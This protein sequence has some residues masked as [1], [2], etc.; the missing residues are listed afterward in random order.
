MCAKRIHLPDPRTTVANDL[1]LQQIEWGSR[2]VDLG[3]GDAQLLDELRDRKN[4]DVLGVELDDE[5]F[6][7]GIARGVPILKADLN[8]GLEDLPSNGFD[9]AVLS[10]T[11][12]QINR[13]LEL[14]QE[15]FRVAHR[16]LVVVPNFAHWRVRIQVAMR[17]R[18]PVTDFLPYEWYESPNVHFLSMLDFRELAA[19]GNF[20][21]AREI[22]IVGNRAVQDAWMPNLRAHSA[23]YLLERAGEMKA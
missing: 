5:A 22:P 8:K 11:L 15:I 20:R 14:L 3:C 1:I 21:I 13:P 19:R 16:A 12:Q 10:Q 4:C 2:V 7:E 18:A 6:L 23:L 17:G 9:Y